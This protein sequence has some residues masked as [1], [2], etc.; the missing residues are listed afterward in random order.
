MVE[1]PIIKTFSFSGHYW[2]AFSLSALQ[3]KLDSFW[4]FLQK[5]STNPEWRALQKQSFNSTPKTYF[6]NFPNPT[7]NC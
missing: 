4:K 5:L 1:K 7:E 6:I 3:E 2:R